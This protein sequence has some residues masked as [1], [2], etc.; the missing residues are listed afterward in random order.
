M[1]GKATGYIKELVTCPNGE[2]IT[3]HE[4]LLAGVLADSHQTRGEGTFPSVETMAREALMDERT[5]RRLL[6]SLER[7]GVIL[8]RHGS[9]Q[10]RGQMTFYFFP[11]LDE[12]QP[13]KTPK[14]WGAEPKK[15][16]DNSVPLFF[17]ER[18]T[19]GGQ[20]EDKTRIPHIEEQE[21][22]QKLSTFPQPP[23][24]LAPGE[25]GGLIPFPS[26]GPSPMSVE[27]AVE[28]VGSG[29]PERVDRAT[30]RVMAA[31][32]ITAR[33]AKRKL[34]A[35]V[36]QRAGRGEDPDDVADRMIAMYEKQAQN[37]RLLFRVVPVLEFYES[38][39]WLDMNRWNWD[40]T[41]V[42]EE[43]RGSEARVGSSWG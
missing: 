29:L 33:R 8:R 13:L 24:P 25:P 15:K 37:S 38:G 18:R 3:R 36:L 27:D 19:E 1:S 9:R 7:K 28:C 21:Q 17:G 39:L 43:Q 41:A 5:A 34:C 16:E 20:K 6:A 42:R 22:E 23:A 40:Q 30:E 26:P 2:R 31:V 32:G 35:V 12:V 4:K 14:I 11:A 10:G